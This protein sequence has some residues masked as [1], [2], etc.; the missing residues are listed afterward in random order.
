MIPPIKLLH[1]D[2]L[3]DPIPKLATRAAWCDRTFRKLEIAFFYTTQ[4]ARDGGLQ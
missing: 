4:P 3:P 2:D 1:T